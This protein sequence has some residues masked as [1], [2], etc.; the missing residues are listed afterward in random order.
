[1]KH[2]ALGP[3]YVVVLGL[4]AML[5]VVA[6]RMLFGE[7]VSMKMLG[8]VVLVVVGITLLRLA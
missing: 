2:E 3:S 7:P 5:A 6:G 4:E 1:M 8:G